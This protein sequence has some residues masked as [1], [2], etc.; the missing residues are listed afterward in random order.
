MMPVQV[1]VEVVLSGEAAIARPAVVRRPGVVAV[2]P[3]PAGP[4]LVGGVSLALAELLVVTVLV[5]V[6]ASA[7]MLVVTVLVAAAGIARVVAVPTALAR[8]AR[9]AAIPVL[10]T[11]AI[12]MVPIAVVAITVIAVTIA[13]L[14]PVAAIPIPRH[15]SGGNRQHHSR[16]AGQGDPQNRALV[17]KQHVKPPLACSGG[18]DGDPAVK[19]IGLR[20]AADARSSHPT[21]IQGIRADP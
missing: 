7:E 16:Q 20:S 11:V 18:F 6:P 17:S 15:R 9:V 14:G 5:A 4:V 13:V 3:V 8:M 10:P 19:F 1:P 21:K 12:A 2:T